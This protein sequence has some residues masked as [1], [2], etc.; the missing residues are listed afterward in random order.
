MKRPGLLLPWL[1]LLRWLSLLLVPVAR[2]YT[3]VRP[4]AIE[5][6]Q[7]TPYHTTYRL[8]VEL[9]SNAETLYTIIGSQAGAL[10]MPPAFQVGA[11]FGV[12]VGGVNPQYIAF[13]KE[14]AFDSWLT[15]GLTSGDTGN[16]LSTAGLVGWDRWTES[17]GFKDSDAAIFWMDPH[18]TT[19]RAHING[20]Q[21]LIVVA[22]LTVKT[23]WKGK[24]TMGLAGYTSSGKQW[25]EDK[26]VWN[27][28]CAGEIPAWLSGVKQPPL[29]PPKR[30]WE[31]PKSYVLTGSI[32]NQKIY[33]NA[34]G[35]YTRTTAK[36]DGAPVY[37]RL[38]AQKDGRERYTLFLYRRPRGAHGASYWTIGETHDE[39]NHQS[40]GPI[41]CHTDVVAFDT[42]G[43]DGCS[44]SPDAPG[45]TCQW[46]ECTGYDCFAFPKKDSDWGPVNAALK[47]SDPSS[48]SSGNGH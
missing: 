33:A 45:C 6:A 12:N 10:E 46:R 13:K 43:A 26:V 9:T 4:E 38:K 31:W 42:S 1:L 30:D 16:V 14:A 5:M 41:N 32:T 7:S 47:V 36:C 17:K 27:V 29:P 40:N 35:E 8:V 44:V 34:R 3:Y 39:S 21:V 24:A 22:Q 23:G 20:K 15:V 25:R 18:K 37:R 19:A 2:A 28:G 48:R 11:P